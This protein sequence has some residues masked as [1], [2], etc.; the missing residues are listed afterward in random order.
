MRRRVILISFAA[1]AVTAMSA[2]ADMT[3]ETT[4]TTYHG[5][6]SSVSPNSSTIVMTPES[7]QTPQQYTYTEKTMWVDPSGNTVSRDA[8][9]NQPVTIYT[10]KQG[11]RTVVTKVVTQKTVSLP[12][13][14]QQTTTTTTTTRPVD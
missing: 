10:E 5:T 1:L 13:G 6:V 2:S 9:Q 11:D 8:I 4:T 14:G 12:T 3:T 7:A